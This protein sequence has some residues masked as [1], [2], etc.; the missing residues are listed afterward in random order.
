M[1]I[2]TKNFALGNRLLVYN[3]GDLSIDFNLTLGNLA[4]NFRGRESYTFRVSRFNVQ[5][6]TIEQAVD[7]LGLKTFD[8]DDE[9]E[10]KYGN[11]YF[12]HKVINTQE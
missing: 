3:S 2:H 4:N 7:W 8:V 12:K 11:K 9:T 5:R 6:L 10:Y 1:G